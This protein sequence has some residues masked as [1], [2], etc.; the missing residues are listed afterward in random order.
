[1]ADTN[2]INEAKAALERIQ[3][4]D[5]KQ[6]SREQALGNQMNFNEAIGPAQKIVDLYKRIPLLMLDDLMN[7]QLQQIKS[8]ADSDFNLFDQINT[9]S[10]TTANPGE[11]RQSII[12]SIVNRRD[13][14]FQSL[15]QFIAYGVA[16]QVDQS[17][18]ES[19]ARATIQ[20]IK[21][22]AEKIN[23]ELVENKKESDAALT[24]I[25]AIAAEQG[26]SQQSIY[27]KTEAETN[28]KNAETW[29]RNVVIFSGIL[30]AM[31]VF[32]FFA[33][34]IEFI[35][36]K[37]NIELIQFMSSKILI[38]AVLGYLLVLSVRNYSSYMHNAVVNKHRQNALLT[39][40]AIAEAAGETGTEDIVLAHAAACI[41]AP[42]ETAFS[43]EKNE[44]GAGSK[45]ILE[46]V[47]KAAPKH[48]D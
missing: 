17:V 28:E 15:W 3:Q 16:R 4:F 6:L 7:T 33:H 26:V 35:A 32:S 18:L 9:F 30:S 1:M 45:S 46:L 47:A 10:L 21:D 40:R 22:Q 14:L 41:F 44:K 8:F 2:I 12:N 19:E 29:L 31:A 34:R 20:G 43:A 13:T 27:F 48:A 36:P 39:Y 37:G 38:F 25:R 42:Q 23:R 5:A 11:Q 24:A